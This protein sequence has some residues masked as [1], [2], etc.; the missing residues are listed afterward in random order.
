[1]EPFE[2][3]YA[4]LQACGC[5]LEVMAVTTPVGTG[6]AAVKVQKNRKARRLANQA[7]EVP[8]P[9]ATAWWW[10]LAVFLFA[11]VFFIGLVIYKYSTP[12]R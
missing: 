2:L 8:P 6:V 1:M 9:P 10:A 11:S 12:P 4:L 7:G 3:G 5:A